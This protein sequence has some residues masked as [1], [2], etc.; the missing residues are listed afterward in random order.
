MSASDGDL[1]DRRAVCHWL[2][3]CPKSKPQDDAMNYR[4][5]EKDGTHHAWEF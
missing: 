1:V 3:S 4:R 2:F 5:Q